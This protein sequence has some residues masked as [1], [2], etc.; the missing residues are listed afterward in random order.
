LPIRFCDFDS[1]IMRMGIRFPISSFYA[2]FM[3]AMGFMGLHGFYVENSFCKYGILL[4]FQISGSRKKWAYRVKPGLG[5]KRKSISIHI[6]K[7]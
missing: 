7:T 6:K 5:Y 4:G 3:Y 2:L 1:G